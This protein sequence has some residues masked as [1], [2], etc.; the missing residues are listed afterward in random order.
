MSRLPRIHPPSLAVDAVIVVGMY[1]LVLNFR[2]FQVEPN[3]QAWTLPFAVFAAIAVVV[4][5]V[6]NWLAGVYGMLSRYMS[7]GQ[8]V[9]IGK[10][11]II[12]VIILLAGVIIWPLVGGEGNFPVPRSVVIAG[13]LTATVVS[14]GLRFSRRMLHERQARKI[15]RMSAGA[16][17]RVLLVGAGQ[18]ADMII[19]EIARTPSLGLQ[20]V[21]L[22][23]DRRDLRNMT[24]QGFPVLGTV[25]DV[26]WIAQAHGVTQ[27]IVAIPSASAEEMVVTKVTRSRKSGMDLELRRIAALFAAPSR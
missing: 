13:G 23:D 21:G 12:S 8:A 2:Y 1:Y 25:A 26:S 18:A 7:L 16:V 14:V 24:I 27:I 11:G 3:W 15:F 22:V 17:E 6:S 9:R 20:V 4:H 5:L 10:A 19:R